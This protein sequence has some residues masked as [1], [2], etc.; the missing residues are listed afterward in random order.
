MAVIAALAIALS[1][2]LP[3]KAGSRTAAT[4][5]MAGTYWILLRRRV[6]FGRLARAGWGSRRP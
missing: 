6:S 2:A 5:G 3:L 4:S 1:Y